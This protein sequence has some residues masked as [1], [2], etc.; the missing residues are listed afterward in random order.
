MAARKKPV[1]PES[2]EQRICAVVRAI[3]RGR[4]ATYGQVAELAGIP[5]G[6]RVAARALRTCP[7][8]L[9]WYRVL[10]K[11]DAR[12]AMISITDAEHA[13]EQRRRLIAEGV[14]FDAQ[15]FIPLRD[16][17]WLPS[18]LPARA[19]ALRPRSE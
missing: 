16:F 2:Q 10:A 18:D 14:R 3:A 15:G 6:H 11:K 1:E 8:G 4:V 19:R 5:R 9:P 7:P 12:R 13:T 17:G